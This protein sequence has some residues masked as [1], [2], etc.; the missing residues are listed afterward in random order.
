MTET[1][2]QQAL[3]RYRLDYM[4]ASGV[5]PSELHMRQVETRLDRQGAG[6][7]AGR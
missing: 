1:E 3:Y 5:E 2:R 6:I 4:I 7:W